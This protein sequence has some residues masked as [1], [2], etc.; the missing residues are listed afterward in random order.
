MLVFDDSYLHQVWNHSNH[1]RIVLFMNF[2]HPCLGDEE[3][4][5]LER[6]R[7]AYEKSPVSQV[8]AHNQGQQLAHTIVRHA[9]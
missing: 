5:V 9:S 8:H 3:I 1:V 6:F 7:T 2:W 4:P